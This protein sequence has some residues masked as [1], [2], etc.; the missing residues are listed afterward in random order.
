MRKFG[1]VYDI[2]ILERQLPEAI[3]FVDRHREQPFVLD[4]LAKPKVA[5]NELQPWADRIRDLARRENVVCKV[6]GLVTEASWKDWSDAQILPYLDTVLEAFGP[7]RL[8]FGSDWPVCLVA[9]TYAGWWETVEHWAAKLT[10]DEREWIFGNTAVQ[11]Y[12][13]LS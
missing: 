13:L 12:G 8:M 11:A 3:A 7:R 10:S 5:K 6:S 2:L 1:L 4:H 9:T